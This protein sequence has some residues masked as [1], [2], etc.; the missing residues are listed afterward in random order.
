[1]N[2]ADIYD[3]LTAVTADLEWVTDQLRHNPDTTDPLQLLTTV[4]PPRDQFST[5]VA[6]INKAIA[7]AV[8]EAGLQ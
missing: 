7:Q 1:M 4:T 8:A 6:H 2:N 5:Q 3:L